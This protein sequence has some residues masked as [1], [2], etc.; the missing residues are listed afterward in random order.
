MKKVGISLLVG[1]SAALI[2]YAIHH[3]WIII[4]L[5]HAS[6]DMPH[7]QT[8]KRSVKLF[9]WQHDTWKSEPTELLWSDDMTHTI[10]HMV[11]QWLTLMDEEQLI[12]KKV[13][14]Q[15]VIINPQSQ[16]LFLSFD[17]TP[18]HEELPAYENYM[19]LNGLLKTLRDNNISFQHL[20][21]LV[22]HQPIVDSPL[23]V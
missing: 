2:F 16:E 14:L 5:P 11:D 21:L 19:I 15:S 7:H 12:D 4:R 1:L 10:K 23:S 20:R 17:R 8:E 6:H 18:F 22:H 3:S 13:S 9:F